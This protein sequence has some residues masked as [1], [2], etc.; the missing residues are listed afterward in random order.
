MPRISRRQIL[1][2][3]ACGFGG[4]ALHGLAA[5]TANAAPSHHPL[6]HFTPRAKRVIFLFMSGG[7]SQ[8]DL[9]DPKPLIVSKHGQAIVAPIDERQIAPVYAN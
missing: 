6:P 1:E 9:F 5:Q 7:P 2:S 8:A 4:L 3:A